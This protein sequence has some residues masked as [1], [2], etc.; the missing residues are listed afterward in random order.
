M[1]FSGEY[2][3]TGTWSMEMTPSGRGQVETILRNGGTVT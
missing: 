3:R 2:T 1:V